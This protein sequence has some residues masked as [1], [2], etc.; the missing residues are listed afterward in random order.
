VDQK[1]LLQVGKLKRKSGKFRAACHW[2]LKDIDC[3]Y[4]QTPDP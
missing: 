1:Q 4:K 3:P 2:G